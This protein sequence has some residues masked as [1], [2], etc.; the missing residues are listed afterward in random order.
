MAFYLRKGFNFGPV[1][2][3][4]SKGGV[5]ISGGITGAR[6]GISP[7]GAY[8][9]GGRKGVYYRK[10]ARKGGSR[11]EGWSR[12]DQSAGPAGDFYDRNLTAE[13]YQGHYLAP[14]GTVE[15]FVDTGACYPSPVRR[16]P[17]AAIRAPELPGSLWMVFLGLIPGL[18]LLFAAYS[19][20][21]GHGYFSLGLFLALAG[22]SGHIMVYRMNRRAMDLLTELR[23]VLDRMDSSAR[24]APG[25]EPSSRG[26]SSQDASS[27]G[28]SSRDASSRGTY[29]HRRPATDASDKERTTHAIKLNKILDDIS[30]FRGRQKKWLVFHGGYH[31][32]EA[33]AESPD[34]VPWEAVSRFEKQ[35]VLRDQELD[36]LHIALFQR[37]FDVLARDHHIS[38]D[39]E[40]HLLDLAARLKLGEAQIGEEQDTL[41]VLSEIRKENESFPEEAASPVRLSPGEKC[42]SVVS[43]RLLKEKVQQ[44]RTINRIRHKY[45]GYEIELEGTICLTD[46]RILIIADGSRSYLLKRIL[47]VVLSLEDATVRLVLDGRKSPVILTTE[48]PA[49]FAARLQ[50]LIKEE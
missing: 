8:I 40:A 6:V 47:D 7:R 31:L 39:E 49:I 44:Y 35:S 50:H 17:P 11:S 22:A 9:H 42:Y 14:G 26:T 15:V 2:L 20:W 45:I 41:A 3:N 37:R 43:G 36:E 28:T 23:L 16:R 10:Y 5:G 4:L 27:R 46:R 48:R 12:S 24:D 38:A 30:G 1:R 29:V 34:F 25:Y 18:M 32:V 19:G 33:F 21:I 13:P